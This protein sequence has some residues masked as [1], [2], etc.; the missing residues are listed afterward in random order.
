GGVTTF[1]FA[2]VAV[3][4]LKILSTADFSRRDRIILASA[5]SIGLATLLVKD[6]ANYIFTYSGGNSALK[7]FYDSLIIILSTPFLIAGI[8]A[9]LL[10]AT[11]P[12]DPEADDAA[13][14]PALLDD[15]A[16]DSLELGHRASPAGRAGKARAEEEEEDVK[17][18]V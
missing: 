4:G 6:W 12:A 15:D 7:G 16:A 11:L 5:L 1:L 18:V 17:I 2:S 3:S 13:Q 8:I 14:R 9:S 10:N